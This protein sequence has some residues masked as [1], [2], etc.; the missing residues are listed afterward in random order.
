MQDLRIANV[1]GLFC[2]DLQRG[3][4]PV[5]VLVLT[6]K[7]GGGQTP[8]YERVLAVSC[9]HD[10]F[11]IDFRIVSEPRNDGKLVVLKSTNCIYPRKD[12][13]YYSLI[14]MSLRKLVKQSRTISLS[15]GER[16]RVRG[17]SVCVKPLTSSQD[18]EDRISTFSPAWKCEKFLVRFN[19]TNL[20]KELNSHPELDSGSIHLVKRTCIDRFRFSPSG[21][22]GMTPI[23]SL[24]PSRE[25]A[26]TL[27]SPFVGGGFSEVRWFC[28]ARKVRVGR[29]STHTPNNPR[30]D[31]RRT[32]EGW[33]YRWTDTPQ[34]QLRA[35]SP[36]WG[37]DEAWRLQF[38]ILRR[39]KKW[40]RWI[41]TVIARSDSDVAIH[42]VPSPRGRV[43]C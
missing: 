20:D 30:Q 13:E 7:K 1:Q 34:R 42:N 21:V 14:T 26:C 29:Y 35:T 41:T 36:A 39:M 19:P 6:L 32:G 8:L 24:L 15:L 5:I 16:A 38:N 4:K 17:L 43:L 40:G 33:Q 37:E 23:L 3:C 11:K 22:D 18:G 25:K 28:Q 31:V 2:V 27:S 10:Y 12:G 9:A